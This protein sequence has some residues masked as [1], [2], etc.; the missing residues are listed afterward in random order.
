M[1]GEDFKWITIICQ[2]VLWYVE[3][4]TEDIVLPKYLQDMIDEYKAQHAQTGTTEECPTIDPKEYLYTKP[5][6][7]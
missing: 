6:K 5:G 3:V 4:H 1:S 7:P 2:I